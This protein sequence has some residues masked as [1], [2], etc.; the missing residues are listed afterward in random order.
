MQ[1]SENQ[2]ENSDSL[3]TVR[4]KCKNLVIENKT[5]LRINE[6]GTF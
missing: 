2:V 4:H 6:D 1:C 5:K 3:F